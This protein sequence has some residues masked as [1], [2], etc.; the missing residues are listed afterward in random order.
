MMTAVGHE[1]CPGR[2]RGP[3]E[4]T[5]GLP[6]AGGSSWASEIAVS[7]L[8]GLEAVP[9][10]PERTKACAA[11]CLEIMAGVRQVQQILDETEQGV[12]GRSRPCMPCAEGRLVIDRLAWAFDMTLGLQ[13]A[14]RTLKLFEFADL[15]CEGRQVGSGA[16]ELQERL[17]A[18]Y[19]GVLEAQYKN[20]LGPLSEC[21]DRIGRL[22][23]EFAAMQMPAKV[24]QA[25]AQP[26]LDACNI[27]DDL[28]TFLL[29]TLARASTRV[30]PLVGLFGM[31]KPVID[32]LD[33]IGVFPSRIALR[34]QRT[35]PAVMGL[36]QAERLLPQAAH[37]EQP[38]RRSK[39]CF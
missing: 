12:Q 34:D 10:G 2:A 13:Q 26:L 29:D 1:T 23:R 19:Q 17:E 30:W 27:S 6:H 7:L 4:G 35:P 22:S 18:E 32:T 39:L 15:M 37:A 11:R 9:C 25:P 3:E 31:M 36:L 16:A 14:A 24:E 5:A 20:I 28:D 8:S 21:K 38:A 33:L